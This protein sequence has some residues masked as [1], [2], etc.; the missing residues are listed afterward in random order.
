MAWVVA[1]LK[2]LSSCFTLFLLFVAIQVLLQGVPL[3]SVVD[4]I[5]RFL[6]GTNYEAPPFEFSIR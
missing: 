1:S 2:L 6:C 5:E 3:Y 4:D